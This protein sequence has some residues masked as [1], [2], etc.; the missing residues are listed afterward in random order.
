MPWTPHRVT[1]DDPVC[2]RAVIVRAAAAN[3]KALIASPDDDYFIVTD[4]AGNRCVLGEL[5]DWNAASEVEALG[6]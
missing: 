3:C 4:A 6:L 1:H 2:E 5:A